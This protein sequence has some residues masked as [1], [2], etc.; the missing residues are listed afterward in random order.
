MDNISRVDIWKKSQKKI[1]YIKNILTEILV[2]NAFAGL[3][4]TFD[5]AEEKKLMSLKMVY[6]NLLN[7]NSK[8]K[9]EWEKEKS[10][11]SRS[12]G[13]FK[14]YNMY[15][16]KITEEEKEQINQKIYLK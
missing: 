5:T 6:R 2:K 15:I 9:K 12:E 10:Q 3:I 11:H 1:L 13:N 14:M 8:R 7:K 4:I 16:I